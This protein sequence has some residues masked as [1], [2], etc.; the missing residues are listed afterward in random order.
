MR[1]TRLTMLI[2][3]ALCCVLGIF[4]K[5]L[6]NPLA[7]VITEALHIPGGIG[8]SFSIMFLTVAVEVARNQKD[9]EKDRLFWFGGTLMGLV[10]GLLSLALG[11][12]GSMGALMPLGFIASGI[13]LD[14]I[15]A[16]AKLLR[17]NCIE[18][19]VFATSLASV[20]GSLIANLLVFHLWGAV[21]W[22]YLCV[23]AL[24]GALFGI[25]GAWVVD[26][27]H[28]LRIGA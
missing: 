21:L 14:V 17:L 27:L 22:L 4:S 15:Y 23:A 9:L 18:R 19:M 16:L 20:L 3:M 28:K 5:Q 13:G 25:L 10:Q 1:R 24:S 11:R 7:N 26:R 2:F 6:V 8:K 12:V